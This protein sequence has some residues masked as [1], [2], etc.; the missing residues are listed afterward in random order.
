M[1]YVADRLGPMLVKVS[2]P[3]LGHTVTCPDPAEAPNATARQEIVLATCS[4]H[5]RRF[6]R[7]TPPT[8]PP[9]RSPTPRAP[10][11]LSGSRA[12]SAP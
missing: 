5:A 6:S 10:S 1:E 12:P 2:G 3:A 4:P 11:R 9:P 7:S 8:S